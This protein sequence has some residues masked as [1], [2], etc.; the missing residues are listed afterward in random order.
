ML[1]LAA[2]DLDPCGTDTALSTVAI[3]HRVKAIKL[4]NRALSTNNLTSEQ[5]NAMLA[6]C[7]TLVFQSALID[8]GLAEFMTFIRGCVL[9]LY[10]MGV[11]N[12]KFLFHTIISEEVV[13]KLDPHL[14]QMPEV[15]LEAAQAGLKS[16]E[17]FQ[18]LCVRETEKE[19][20]GHLMDAVKGLFSTPKEG[21]LPTSPRF[22]MKAC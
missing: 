7:Y 4:L 17:A 22:S 1:A 3:S 9:V 5:G 6:T 10:Q 8:D 16:L 20:H 19:F 13:K 21:T 14:K 11:R 2:S 15:D 12:L 18:H